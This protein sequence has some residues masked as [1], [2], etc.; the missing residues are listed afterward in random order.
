MN[1]GVL[2]R[3]ED[4]SWQA[5]ASL[6]GAFALLAAGACSSARAQIVL[7]GP[8]SITITP[9]VSV[10]ETYTSNVFLSNTNK[11]S[12]LITQVSPGIQIVSRGGRIRGSLDYSLDEL[13]YARNTSG[14]RSQNSLNALGTIEAVDNW[15][16]IDFSGVIGQQAISAFGTPATNAAALNGNSTETSVFRVS[17]H[18]AGRLGS[19]ADY[20]ARYSLLTS[21]SQADSVSGVDSQELSLRLSGTGNRRGTGW[22]FDADHQSFDYS[23]GRSTQSQRINGQ[24]NFGLTDQFGTYVKGGYESSDFETT[25]DERRNFVALGLSWNPNSDLTFNIDRDN[26]GATGLLVNWTPS[27][28]T[29]VAITRERRLYGDS[30]SIALTYRTPNTAWTYTDTRSAVAN[31]GLATVGAPTSL[32]DVLYA[33]FAA[34]ET[35]PLKREQFGSY[36]QANGIRPNATAITGFLTSAVSLQSL[37]QLSFALFGSRST[38]TLIATQ[39]NSRR[40]DTVSQA[41]DDLSN[42]GNVRQSGF[43]IAYAYRFTA[44]TMFNAVASR[45]RSSDSLGLASTSSRSIDVNL[46]SRL[47][48]ETTASVGAR[49]VIFSSN[50]APYSETAVTGNLNVQF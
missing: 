13:W 19:F 10:T 45:Q 17:P 33:Q 34:T 37:R 40:L 21:R 47:S 27:K 8:S 30:H 2:V 23:V 11:R 32:Y 20:E 3:K 46:S 6:W 44:N 49:R 31:T 25:S 1:S 14:R 15:A 22:S 43:S 35:D 9:H 12:E 29:S 5:A 48:K 42:S 4:L 24:V 50:T 41:V 18:I 16:F 28:R 36:L 38:V 26:R 7:D 39:S